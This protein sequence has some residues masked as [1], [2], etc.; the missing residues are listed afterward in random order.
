TFGVAEPAVDQVEVSEIIAARDAEPRRLGGAETVERSTINGQVSLVIPQHRGEQNAGQIAR[1]PAAGEC[2]ARFGGSE[3][4]AVELRADDVA[5]RER[6]VGITLN[7]PGVKRLGAGELS[8]S[9]IDQG[10][11]VRQGW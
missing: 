2:D 10:N 8:D 7:R 9:H 1:V 4:A 3:L 11:R 5:V 6:K